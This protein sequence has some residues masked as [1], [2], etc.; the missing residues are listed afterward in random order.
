MAEAPQPA[1]RLS[2]SHAL[3]AAAAVA[4]VLA[5]QAVR[6]PA[7][8]GTAAADVSAEADGGA[9]SRGQRGDAASGAP[10]TSAGGVAAGEEATLG[11]PGAASLIAAAG[12]RPA[13]AA[14]APVHITMRP[15]AL[16]VWHNTRMAFTASP[17]EPGVFTR[18]V[19]HFEDGSDPVT[20]ASVTHVFPESVTDR[21]VTLEA[22]KGP[23]KPLVISKRVPIE[24]LRV[25][26]I[27]GAPDAVRPVPK[28]RGV[29]LALLGAGAQAP[30]AAQ[31]A[32]LSELGASAFVIF[33]SPGAAGGAARTLAAQGAST[34]VLHLDTTLASAEVA[35]PEQ[36]LARAPLTVVF[37]PLG[38]V[39]R[40]PQ[41]GVLALDRVAF[42][43]LDSRAL[44][45]SEAA[46]QRLQRA[47][48]VGSAYPGLLLLS[49][50]PL[51]P[52]TDDEAVADR[53][54]RVYEHALRHG[55]RAVVSAASGV[56]FDARYG[57]LATVA[58]GQLQPSGCARL[59][60]TDHCQ[61]ATATLV[62]I[63]RSGAV[64]ALHLRLPSLTAWLGRD[65]LPDT[66]GKYRR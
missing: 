26:P 2:W 47:L 38:R 3:V 11:L 43:P 13:Q 5:W 60:G 30:G 8:P 28:R 21:H 12:G 17:A 42:V 22:W 16:R 9:P 48:E 10:D 6:E 44:T 64:R 55:V 50:R 54:F 59:A 35:L 20:G 33:G 7:S 27:D 61:A 52:L 19:W 32:R 40:G 63:P 66:V 39:T 4:A 41:G 56:A 14:A 65:V 45:S 24:R 49:A 62:D 46:M 15:A 23:G 18:F 51:S 37:D 58:V 53:A 25:V 31:L 29:R 57:G 36:A 1:P 34:P